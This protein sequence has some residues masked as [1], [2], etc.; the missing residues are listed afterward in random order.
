[1]SFAAGD[2]VDALEGK[3]DLLVL[4]PLKREAGPVVAHCSEVFRVVGLLAGLV[5]GLPHVG[6]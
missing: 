4:L 5:E 6:C 2:E 3:G 1:M